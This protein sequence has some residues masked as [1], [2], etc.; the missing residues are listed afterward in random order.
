[1][2]STPK[3]R[4]RL[5]DGAPEQPLLITNLLSGREQEELRTIAKLITFPHSGMTIFSRGTEAQF[6]YVIDEGVVRITRIS[7]DGQRRI[8]AFMVCGDLFG[9]PDRG[10]YANTA[11]TVGPA[12]LY[13]LPWSRLRQVMARVPELQFSLLTKLAS[14]FRQAQRQMMMLGQQS[15]HQRLALFL[16][17]FMRNPGFFDETNGIL[18]VPVNRFDLADYLGTTRETAA[19]AFA[20]LEADGI[21]RRID[22]HTIEIRNL[23]GLQQVQ[24]GPARRCSGRKPSGR[25]D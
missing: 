24:H 2:T 21:V 12:A 23:K 5:I 20:R 17:D 25:S 10:M 15:A 4:A 18:H 13:R 3:I 6:V 22:P 14:D 9:I 8:L 7:S 16:L 11:E 19:R 1:V